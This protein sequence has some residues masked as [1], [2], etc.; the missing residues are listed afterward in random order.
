MSLGEP[1]TELDNCIKLDLQL[2]FYC[3]FN[4][5][6]FLAAEAC[7]AYDICISCDF[8]TKIQENSTFMGFFVSIVIE[9]LENKYSIK[10]DRSKNLFNLK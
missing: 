1:H 3:V 5:F 4:I 2:E 7:V 6:A 10:L 9:G 8:L